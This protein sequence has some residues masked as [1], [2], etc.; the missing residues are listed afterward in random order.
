[1]GLRYQQKRLPPG[2]L[3][4]MYTEDASDI[5]AGN[6]SSLYD[7]YLE[8]LGMKFKMDQFQQQQDLNERKVEIAEQ[9]Q[10][11]KQEADERNFELNEF[12]A[13]ASAMSV[14][15]D[16]DPEAYYRYLQSN[17]E[18]YPFLGL[19]ATATEYGKSV[20]EPHRVRKDAME[21][22][23]SG[24]YN[25]RE[26]LQLIINDLQGSKKGRDF[27]RGFGLLPKME[28]FKQHESS[29][30]S[31]D[32]LFAE[33]NDVGIIS[34]EQYISAQGMLA[35]SGTAAQM[36]QVGANILD[37]G[38]YGAAKKAGDIVRADKLLQGQIDMHEKLTTAI[39]SNVL[40]PRY[41]AE[42]K[43]R[44]GFSGELDKNQTQRAGDLALQIQNERYNY[45]SSEFLRLSASKVGVPLGGEGEEKPFVHSDGTAF[46][47]QAELDTYA[48]S[49]T[50]DG[51]EPVSD[52]E[53]KF[54]GSPYTQG[55]VM[56][57][58]VE[59]YPKLF[60]KDTTGR[61]QWKEDLTQSMRD[62]ILTKFTQKMDKQDPAY[63]GRKNGWR[64]IED[65]SD[66]SSFERVVKHKNKDGT[67][68]IYAVQK[69]KS[70]K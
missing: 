54:R 27:I 70:I 10:I 50:G 31:W 51:D 53:A 29:K 21:T 17:A 37:I 62:S 40:Y 30:S 25:T 45:H 9:Q 60:T 66:A 44:L 12:K 41:L 35:G 33:A 7:T 63:I 3:L 4:D 14:L 52:P 15:A 58:A 1:M 20:L 11:D 46:T 18:K 39:D 67:I 8:H 48:Q 55:N 56:Q 26:D 64:I 32:M 59:S 36:S 13:G 28:E 22:Y 2:R 16:E 42:A 61:W 6:L 43:K 68:T 19:D 57:T 38:K 47:T 24:A 5:V 23:L 49:L 69:L 34:D 65:E